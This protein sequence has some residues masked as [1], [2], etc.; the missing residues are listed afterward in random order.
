MKGPWT[1]VLSE[2]VT[3]KMNKQY[4]LIRVISN[5]KALNNTEPKKHIGHHFDP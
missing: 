4:I 3:N 1:D 2:K 5:K